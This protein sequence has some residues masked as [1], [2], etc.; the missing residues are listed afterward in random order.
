MPIFLVLYFSESYLLQSIGTVCFI[1]GA[2][3]DHW[4]GKLARR[5]QE[6]TEFGRFWD[7]LADKFLVLSAFA[8][9]WIREDFNFFSTFVLLYILIIAAR[10]LGITILRL[11]G[12]SKSSPVVTSF[13]GKMKT[14]FQ[15]IAIIFSLVYFNTRDILSEWH[16]RVDYISDTYV[17][18]VIHFL[19]LISMIVTVVSG[20]MY[21]IPTNLGR[22]K[23]FSD[24]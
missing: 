22:Q 19:I 6:V 14:T 8:A 7:P 4:D 17:M 10:E 15:L 2:I 1:A 16:Y 3:T 5:R 23:E 11:W 13:W 9:I 12:I 18:P 20:A 24:G 21:L